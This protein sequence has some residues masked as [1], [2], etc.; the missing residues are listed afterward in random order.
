MTTRRRYDLTRTGLQI[1]TWPL[2]FQ[3][4]R[5][6]KVGGG[7]G[8]G[9]PSDQTRD[10]GFELAHFEEDVAELLGVF[11]RNVITLEGNGDGGMG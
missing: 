9:T 2:K 7:G 8:Q 5:E 4:G 10:L 11:E 1:M 6:E 3:D